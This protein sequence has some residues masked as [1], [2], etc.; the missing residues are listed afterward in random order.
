MPQQ[1]WRYPVSQAHGVAGET[2]VD[3]ETPFH[4]PITAILGGKVTR[5]LGGVGWQQEIDIATSYLGKPATETYLHIDVPQVTAGETIQPGQQIG[6]SGGETFDQAQHLSGAQSPD[7]PVH[8][9]GPHV[10]F[11]LFQGSV[12]QN[13]IDPTALVRGG[14]QGGGSS[15]SSSSS[16][17]MSSQGLSLNPADWVSGLTDFVKGTFVRLLIGV[18]GAVF[19]IVGLAIIAKA[20]GSDI[21]PEGTPAK[22]TVEK[23]AEAGAIA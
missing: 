6:L 18:L 3:L 12:W 15:T 19:V 1:W 10:E 9:S 17:L 23:V 5:I 16:Q 4:T 21:L 22:G 2:G 20:S 14:P 13:P 7:S 8:S 11:N